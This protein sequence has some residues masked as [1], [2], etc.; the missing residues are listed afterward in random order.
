LKKNKFNY[1][2]DEKAKKYKIYYIDYEYHLDA[3]GV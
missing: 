2:E 1:G 3:V